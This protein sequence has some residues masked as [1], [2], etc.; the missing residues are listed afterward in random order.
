MSDERKPQP[1]DKDYKGGI[2]HTTVR[3]NGKSYDIRTVRDENG[4]PISV[5]ETE[6]IF[7]IF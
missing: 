3:V 2:F 4:N 6:K 7:G 5:T 1:G